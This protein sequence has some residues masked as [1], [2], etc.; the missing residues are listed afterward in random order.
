[1]LF[2]GLLGTSAGF[3]VLAIREASSW[4]AQV[5]A[6][7]KFCKGCQSRED[8]GEDSILS[9]LQVDVVIQLTVAGEGRFSSLAKREEMG[10]KQ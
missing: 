9:F 8:S 5:R 3:L 1:M 4:Q 10:E 2:V 6:E 7:T